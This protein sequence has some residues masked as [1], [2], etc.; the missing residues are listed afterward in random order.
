M[1]LWSETVWCH[2]IL[3]LKTVCCRLVCLLLFY[4]VSC[5]KKKSFILSQKVRENEFCKILGN[6]VCMC[7][8]TAAAA[9][10]PFRP[11]DPALCGSCPLVTPY[12][13]RLGD[14]P[15]THSCMCGMVRVVMSDSYLYGKP[16]KLFVRCKDKWRKQ[17][18]Q[19][20][21]R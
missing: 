19:R 16:E 17:N 7:G 11:S 13:C 15:L 5:V 1:P 10:P 12:Y 21:W 3:R 8:G 6:M 18:K 14:L 20:M 2:Y 9:P 4:L